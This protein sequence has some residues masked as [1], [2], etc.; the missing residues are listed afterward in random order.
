MVSPGAAVPFAQRVIVGIGELS[1]TNNPSI[2]LS[3]YGLGS[4]VGIAAYDPIAKAGGLMHVMLPD[5]A[6][7]AKKAAEQPALFANTGLPLLI[8]SLLELPA[9]PNR[10]RFLIAGGASMMCAGNG[11]QIG[12]SNSRVTIDFLMQNKLLV[13]YTEL[14]GTVNRT[15]HLEIGTGTLTLKTPTDVTVF[16]LAL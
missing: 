8:H 15:L 16:S 2:T 1:V 11:F 4:C 14:G 12:D 10:L 6:I 9:E 7:D 3:T 5:S 13:C